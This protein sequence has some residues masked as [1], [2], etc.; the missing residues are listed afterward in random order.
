MVVIIHLCAISAV[1]I[2][3]ITVWIKILAVLLLAVSTILQLW[4][5]SAR[6]FKKAEWLA[7]D[8]WRLV[9][10]RGTEYRV[11]NWR[12]ICSLPGLIILQFNIHLAVK[13]HLLLCTDSIG[14][15]L[16]R[17]MRVRLAR[18]ACQTP[19]ERKRV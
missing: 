6:A 2:A 10:G 4:Q 18:N 16:H 12:S 5:Q 11:D 13:H 9:T 7:D 14:E 15:D 17:Q 1:T 3:E 8:S 19:E